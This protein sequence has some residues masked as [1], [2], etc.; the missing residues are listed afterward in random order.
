MCR[1][2]DRI[3][4]QEG[5]LVLT[6][7]V[8]IVIV[9]LVFGVFP[10]IVLTQTPSGPAD[11]DPALRLLEEG[12]TTLGDKPL[13]DAREALTRLTQQH[14][15]NALYFYYLASVNRYRVEAYA[16]HG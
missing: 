11:V 8:R 7:F 13:S 15:D 6:R 10:S 3:L 1:S 4:D 9:A 2:P 12:R 16:T 5:M 14:P